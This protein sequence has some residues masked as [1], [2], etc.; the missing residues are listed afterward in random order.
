MGK[1]YVHMYIYIYIYVW[2]NVENHAFYKSGFDQWN[3]NYNGCTC[4]DIG[5][6]GPQTVL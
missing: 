5:D 6:Y 1:T 3:I 4:Y 2:Q